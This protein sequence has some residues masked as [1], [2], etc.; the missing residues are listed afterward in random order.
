MVH[1]AYFHRR[2]LALGLGAGVA[3]L[4]LWEV[5]QRVFGMSS[6]AGVSFGA[7]LIALALL[8]PLY[9]VLSRTRPALLVA[10]EI[11]VAALLPFALIRILAPGYDLLG[12]GGL[13]GVLALA[14]ST[15]LAQWI[16]AGDLLDRRSRHDSPVF[17]RSFRLAAPPER[18]WAALTPAP[19]A[20]PSRTGVT[21]LPSLTYSPVGLDWTFHTL[22]RGPVGTV[23]SGRYFRVDYLPRKSNGPL[24]GTRGWQALTLAPGPAGTTMVQLES[25]VLNCPLR[26]RLQ[27]FLGDC[28]NA[29][30][31][32]LQAAFAELSDQP[33]GLRASL[34][35]A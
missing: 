6:P 34:A 24:A 23:I 16:I 33:G 1:P 9:I 2:R 28:H 22:V 7:A 12:A 29:Q 30:A 8:L 26:W 15:A 32:A 21:T 20:I 11:V 10:V 13:S 25:Q 4:S 3:Y 35:T 19:N 17:S 5:P 31:H 14:A 18:V 27:W